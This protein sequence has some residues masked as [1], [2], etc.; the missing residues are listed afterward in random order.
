[1]HH[2]E[3]TL[4]LSNTEIPTCAWAPSLM[5]PDPRPTSEHADVSCQVGPMQSSSLLRRATSLLRG[6]VT[7][8]THNIQICSARDHLFIKLSESVHLRSAVEYIS[9]H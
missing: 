1:M 5:R 6:A 4:L 3:A 9:V 8:T 2:I 7:C